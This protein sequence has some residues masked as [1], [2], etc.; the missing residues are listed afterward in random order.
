MRVE[1]GFFVFSFFLNK[2]KNL[3]YY[4]KFF[5]NLSF[6]FQDK[7]NA[8]NAKSVIQER[9]QWFLQKKSQFDQQHHPIATSR[10]SFHSLSKTIKQQSEFLLNWLVDKS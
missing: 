9:R 7:R 8:D 10:G 2:K 1:G 3:Y 6:T 4:E 5:L